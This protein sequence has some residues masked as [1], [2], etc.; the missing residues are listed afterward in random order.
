ME[1]EKKTEVK[2]IEPLKER[3]QLII[4]AMNYLLEVLP[5][6]T[7]NWPQILDDLLVKFPVLK[8]CNAYSPAFF[9]TIGI[10]GSDPIDIEKMLVKHLLTEMRKFGDNELGHKVQKLR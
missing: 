9:S 4:N 3:Y 1:I 5:D 10:P 7:Q 2:G 8:S 6:T